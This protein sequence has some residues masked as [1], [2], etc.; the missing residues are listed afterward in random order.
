[1]NPNVHIFIDEGRIFT[2]LNASSPPALIPPIPRPWN[3]Y[4][5]SDSSPD[6]IK[7][8]LTTQWAYE[9]RPWFPLIPE[10]PV[11]DGAI[12]G[13]LNHSFYSLPIEP[14]SDGRYTLRGDVRRAWENLEQKLLWCQTCL[15]QNMPFPWYGQPPRTPADYGY[16]RSHVDAKLA[17]KVALR[18]RDAFL[19]I[20]ALC[21]YFIM[22]RLESPTNSPSKWTS[23]LTKDPQCSIPPA[24]VVE[25]SRTFV[26]DFTSAVPRTGTIINSA[27]SLGWDSDVHMFERFNVPTWVYWPP[28]GVVGKRWKNHAPCAE[29]IAVATEKSLWGDQSDANPWGAQFDGNP[30]GSLTD[31]DPWAAQAN[32]PGSLQLNDPQPVSNADTQSPPDSSF[33][34]KPEAGS[35]QRP[36]E[37]WQQ[38][39]AR[40]AAQH[41]E[42][43]EKETPSQRSARLNRIEMVGQ[44][45]P[46]R[47][48]KVKVFEW[49]P[50]DEHNGFLLRKAVTKA[51]IEGVWGNYNR[52]TR[53]Y[54]SFA[55]QW[56]LC[57]ALNPDS[58][59]DGDDREDDDDIM[60]PLPIR[61]PSNVPPPAP[62][63][64]SHDI[65]RYFGQDVSL[66]SRH[67][68]I[69]GLVPV[70]HHHFGYRLNAPTSAPLYGS[71]RLEAWIK[72][73]T[74]D[75][76][77][78]LLGD[79]TTETGMIAEPQRNSITYYISYLVN[80]KDTELD[81]IPPDVWDLGPHPSLPIVHAH[82][83][84]SYADL[85]QRRFYIIEPRQS[86]TLVVWTLAVPDPITAVMCLR[87]NWGSDMREIALA[88]LKRGMSFKTLQRMAVAPTLRRPL[89]ELRTY[90]LG[91]RAPPFRAVYADYAVYEQLRHEF[92]NRP[93]A[94]AAFLHGGLVWRLALHSLG[95]DHL[96]SVL[97]GISTEAVPFGHL[98]FWNGQ[99]YYDDGLSDQEIDFIC[100]TY[101]IEKP[102]STD[103]VSWWPR[104]NAWDASG[105]NLGFWSA[106]C[107]DW[108]QK[109][110]DNIRE[111]VSRARHSS[112]SD[113][114]GPM[115]STQWKRSLKFNPGTNKLMQNMSAACY[116][117]M[118]RASVWTDT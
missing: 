7:D 104:P 90:T 95:F 69:E 68:G 98:L 14:T 29:A 11:F 45:L 22:H 117:H 102:Q 99:T 100:G 60:P 53:I 36:G 94:R 56:D 91:H 80:L 58:E 23:V 38:F 34:P 97:D 51:N 116:D 21:T 112:T 28:D 59:P 89:T 33:F 49:E 6:N 41:K 55:N 78:K 39:F 71:I 82:I 87:R 109:R 31:G 37:D 43:E 63:S 73:M 35:G 76:V 79:S 17:K 26:G 46:G 105:L 47:S 24:W 103:V 44:K 19:G 3:S 8:V 107:E 10:N 84:V 32:D 85:S 70:L 74:W 106:R 101:Y 96:P 86:P 12:F 9:T 15:A 18:S 75:H 61:G 42:K 57:L 118:S 30:W 72:K 48:S 110:L 13:C 25:L 16:T 62:S 52:F 1:M 20:A 65:Y 27:H 88:L 5:E 64:F 92:M 66:S 111:G 40:Q 77:R 113:A 108:F 93:R 83:R 81:T 4:L 115:T 54:N 114:N 50:Q 67:T 2:S